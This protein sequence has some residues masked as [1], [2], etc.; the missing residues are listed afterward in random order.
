M[1]RGR[2]PVEV[3]ELVPK[4]AVYNV[5]ILLER[6][7]SLRLIDAGQA[8]VADLPKVQGDVA[9][10]AGPTETIRD[11]GPWDAVGLNE[12]VGPQVTEWFTLT[13]LTAFCA[14]TSGF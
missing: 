10:L 4:V 14:V 13:L 7:P 2:C 12:V 5:A 8:D 3:R 1:R 9:C 6:S 11:S